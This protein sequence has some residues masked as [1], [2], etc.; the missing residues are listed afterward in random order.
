MKNY[1]AMVTDKDTGKRVTIESQYNTKKDFIKD[2]RRNGYRVNPLY[3]KTAEVFDYI[4]DNTN[5]YDW[6]WR[7]N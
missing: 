6:D 2:L 1:K 7:E 3:V 4:I 5:C